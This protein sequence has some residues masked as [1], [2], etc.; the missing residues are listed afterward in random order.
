MGECGV[1]GVC[2]DGRL[3]AGGGPRRGQ[4]RG[5]GGMQPGRAQLA[6]CLPA[7]PPTLT[8]PPHSPPQS[9]HLRTPAATV[10]P[11]P[12]SAAP[13]APARAPAAHSSTAQ[14]PAARCAGAGRGGRG[15]AGRLS[16]CDAW[17]HVLPAAP[18]LHSRRRPQPASPEAVAAA[19]E[20]GGVGR[21]VG[22]EALQEAVR[23]I[24]W[25]GGW[26]EGGGGGGG[27]GRGTWW[28]AGS[29]PKQNSRRSRR[30]RHSRRSGAH[31]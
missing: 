3:E 20:V 31:Q 9:V 16:T 8:Y 25:V 21:E 28:G 24:I 4:A 5:G 17:A 14:F 15:R 30:G 18:C 10:P 23:A 27:R 2:M 19:G 7:P 6:A 12:P 29:V 26:G 1:G 13:P 11:P 22:V